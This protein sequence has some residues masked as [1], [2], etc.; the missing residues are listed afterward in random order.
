[1]PQL[2]HL[3]NHE[4]TVNYLSCYEIILKHHRDNISQLFS[5]FMVNSNLCDMLLFK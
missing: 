5:K 3:K 2:C 1:M 4:L